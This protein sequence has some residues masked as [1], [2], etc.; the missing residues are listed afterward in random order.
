MKGRI[1]Y[2]ML[3]NNTV[4]LAFFIYNW[5]STDRIRFGEEGII[6]FGPQF[7]VIDTSIY[8]APFFLSFLYLAKLVLAELLSATRQHIALDDP[9]F[10]SK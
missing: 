7:S 4:I 10:F 6:D 8:C 2:F 9:G 1:L 3:A 5:V